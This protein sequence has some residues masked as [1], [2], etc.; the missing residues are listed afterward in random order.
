[1]KNHVIVDGSNI[2]TEGRTQPSL[3]QLSEAVASLM[4]EFPNVTITVVVDATFGHRINKKE[5]AEFDDAV[6]NNELVA[7]PAG[8]IGRG[9]AFVLSIANKV[10]GTILSNDSYQ[11]FHGK[12]EWL[13][14]E[15]RLL[16]GKPVPNVGWVFVERL[17]VR[18]STSRR[19]MSSGGRV[20]E[21]NTKKASASASKPMPVPK[22]P[23]P[24]ARVRDTNDVMP[25]LTFVEKSPV[26]S[27][28]KAR[29]D[30]YTSHGAN[31][32]IGEVLGYM[33]LR[34]ISNPAPRSARDHFKIGEV[35]TVVVAGFNAGR[36][37]VEL[38]MP[39]MVAVVAKPVAKKKPVAKPVAK[40]KPVAKPVA[41]KKPVAKPVAKKKPAAKT[42]RPK[43]SKKK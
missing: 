18:G 40:K 14:D 9:D 10:N 19:A 11:E 21:K 20:V 38:G 32:S 22:A 24:G 23:P 30:A 13:F 8:A 34:L 26:G 16:G 7:P 25:F 27:T 5:Q 39:E 15:G 4:K 12:Y 41:K 35:V 37:S 1:M 17:P 36:R 31:L 6:N 33:P 3:A 29:V 28:I 2:A 42:S 43:V